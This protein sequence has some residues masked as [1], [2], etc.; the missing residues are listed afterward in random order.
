MSS[1]AA[2][3]LFAPETYLALERKATFKTNISPL[4]YSLC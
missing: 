3:T 4:R 1:P 2:Q